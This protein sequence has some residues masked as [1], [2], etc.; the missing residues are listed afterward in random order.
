MVHRSPKLQVLPSMAL[1]ATQ[2]M[3][4][5]SEFANSHMQSVLSPLLV[6]AVHTGLFQK[7]RDAGSM[8]ITTELSP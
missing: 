7:L 2:V 6:V 5:F 3:G 4:T 8:G 1:F